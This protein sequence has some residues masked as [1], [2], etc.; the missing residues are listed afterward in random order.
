MRPN[1]I[2]TDLRHVTHAHSNVDWARKASNPTGDKY[3]DVDMYETVWQHQYNATIIGLIQFG[4]KI[5]EHIRKMKL[6]KLKI[7]STSR[8][9]YEGEEDESEDEDVSF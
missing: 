2:P 7:S 5:Y 3:Y 8:V 9:T 1:F 4:N 6:N